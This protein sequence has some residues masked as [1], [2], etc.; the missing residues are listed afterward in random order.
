M[1]IGS[2]A[3]RV[4]RQGLGCGVAEAEPL[5]DQ[6]F[7]HAE[8]QRDGGDGLAGLGQLREGDHPI[9]GV[10]GD[11]DDILGQRNLAGLD[12]LGLHHAGHRV[13]GIEDAVLDQLLHGPEAATTA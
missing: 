6:P 3:L 11:A 8:T 13:V 12:T 2:V 4:G 10:H 7:R 9:G 1:T 5:L